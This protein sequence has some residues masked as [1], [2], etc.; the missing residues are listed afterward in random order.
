MKEQTTYKKDALNRFSVSDAGKQ[1]AGMYDPGYEHDN[2]GIGSV[3]NIKGIKTHETVENALKIVENLKHRAGKDAEG[4]TGDG[5]GILLQISHKFFSKAAKQL[6]IEL[7]EERDYGVGMFFFPQDELKRNRA[8]KMFEVIVGKEG[9]EFLG[10]R[11]VPTDP[12]KLGQKAVDCMPYYF[13]VKPIKGL[14]LRTSVNFT[15]NAAKQ[16]YYQSAFLL[17]KSYTGNKS[18]PDLTSID[19][20][21]LS[22][23]GYNAYWSTTATY[24]V[25]FNEKHHLN[26]MIGYDFEYNSDFEVQQDDRTDS[27]NPIAY[28]NTSITNVNG[29]K[30]WTGSSEYSNYVFDAMFARL[31]YDY[32]YKYVL[33]GSVRRDR[34]SKFGPDKRAG[35]FYS[36]SLAWNITEEDF[37]KDI[38]WLDIAKLRASYGITGND[39]IGND[40]AWISTISSDQNVVFGTTAIPTYYPSGYSNRQ[41]GWEKNKQMDL[42]FDIGVFNALNIVVDL[43]KRTSDIVMPANIPNF[44]G[45]AGSVYMNAGQIEN[46][47][48]EI[49]VSATPFKGDFSWE[50][51]L[52]WSKNN[53]KIL[54][55]ANNQNQLANASAGT[56]WGNVMRNYV[57]RPMG[58]MYMLKVIGTFNTEKDLAQYA[59]NGTQDIGDLIFEDYNKDGTIDVNDYQLVGNYQPDFTFGWNNTF[60]YKDFDL[61]VTIDGQCGG[62]VIY[63]AARAFSLNRYDDNVLAE[64][65]LGRWKSSTDPGNGRSH[66]AGTNNLGSNIGPSTRYLYDADF[67]RIRNVSLGYTLPKKFCKIIG[68]ENMRISANVQNLWTFDKY[69]G[70]SVEAN[71]E[72]NSATNNG[73]DFGGYP[74]SRTFTFGLNFNF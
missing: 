66:K 1:A 67:L 21:R 10:W 12:T 17:G 49:Q 43:Y 69:P 46:K 15:T 57:G 42:G 61:A 64:S 40:Y 73:V 13:E 55:L 24:D 26:T 34:S 60:I 51:T 20:Y 32:N 56:K 45:I 63:A 14:T 70:Y 22:G 37:M 44:N 65:G 54:S 8:K 28:N 11:E 30:L 7:G 23:F 53:N 19:G 62:N 38:H 31:V 72:G 39:Q 33:S 48:I 16:D 74:I 2:C 29:A 25:T 41:L 50:T 36:G 18:T 35:W 3:V 9:M 68:I 71:Y 58:D 47:G 5:V 52:S 27:D 59:K 6:G 4:K